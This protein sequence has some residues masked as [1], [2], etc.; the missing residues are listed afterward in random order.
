MQQIPFIK[1]YIGGLGPMLF[2]LV[3]KSIVCVDDI[4]RRGKNLSVREVLGLVSNL[5]ELKGCKVALTLNDEALEED[6]DEFQRYLEK[7]VDT[8]LK[9]AP[10]AQECVRIAI[11]KDGE[12]AKLLAEKCVALGIANI[13]LVKRIER[14][15]R[16]VEPMLKG[17]D[18]QV[19]KQAVSSLALLGWSVYEPRRAP[20]IDY[21]QNRRD[22]F[23]TRKDEVVPANEAAWNA[24]LD[25][26]GRRE[27]RDG[28]AFG[29]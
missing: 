4:E 22:P 29:V 9:I 26:Y 6:K 8:S 23:G 16:Q 20:S 1:N 5:K 24:L 11:A 18:D 2:S 15:V 13:S 17:F 21:L 14:S 19:L 12:T 25:A 3:R 10:S 27:W 7:V 28:P